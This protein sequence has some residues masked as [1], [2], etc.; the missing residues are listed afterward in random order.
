MLVTEPTGSA[1][2]DL[3]TFDLSKVAR[4]SNETRPASTAYHP[5]I[6]A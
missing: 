2:S 1:N 6:H 5:R 4:T 3:V